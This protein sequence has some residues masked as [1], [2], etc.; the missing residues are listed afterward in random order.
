MG[1]V[2]HR[3]KLK[4]TQQIHRFL[5]YLHSVGFNGAP[6]PLGLR[7]DTE[8]VSYIEGDVIGDLINH[9]L[10]SV[11][12]STQVLRSAARL[13]RSYHDASVPYVLS[14]NYNNEL[15]QLPPCLLPFEVMCHGDFAP[16][17]VVIKDKMAVGIIDFDTCHPD[18]RAR[19]I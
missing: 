6:I 5:K 17:N 12:T 3:P 18:P 4:A 19:R 13:L 9:P 2:V 14:G 15:W 8:V 11:V 10:S 1:N 16:Y 7:G